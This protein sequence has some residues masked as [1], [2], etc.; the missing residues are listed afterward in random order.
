LHF[1]LELIHGHAGEGSAENFF[2]VMS[3]ELR[4]RLTVAGEHGFERLDFF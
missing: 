2:E 4:H 1:G 3:R